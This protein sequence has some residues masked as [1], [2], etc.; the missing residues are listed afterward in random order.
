MRRW[1][2][3]V[4]L[5]VTLLGSAPASATAAPTTAPAEPS[6]DPAL[7]AVRSILGEQPALL[8]RTDDQGRREVSLAL[9]D[10]FVAMPRLDARQKAE[11][12]GYLARPTD[13][14][15][16]RFGDGYTVGARKKCR[17]HIC[18]HW[19]P[20]TA[21]APPGNAW[22]ETNLSYL[23]KVWRI[24]VRKL[25]YRKPIS[26]KR[27]GG[28]DKLDVYLKDLGGRGVY[29]YCAPEKRL[30]NRQ[31]LA[32]GYCV[33][34]NDFSQEQYGTPPRDTMRVTAAHEFFHAVQYSYDYGE[35]PWLM[36][37]TATW[38]EERVADD[39]NDNRQYLA[40][41]Q[42]GQ[43]GQSLD[44]FK[45]TGFNQYGNWAFFEYLTG[46]FG[47]GVVRSIWERAGAHRGGGHQYSTTA[48]KGVLEKR[49]GF[50]QV[51]R[52]FAVAN[53]VPGRTYD[54]G[55]AWPSAPMRKSWVLTKDARRVTSTPRIN[56][57]AAA[58]VLVRP[59][60]GVAA[61]G[62]KLRVVV[63]GPKK[64]TAPSA[65][66]LVK[67]KHGVAMKPIRLNGKGNGR[68]S[69]PFGSRKVR[70]ATVT[71]VNASTRFSCW[72]RTSWSCQGRARDNKQPFELT[73]TAVPPKR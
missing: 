59:G 64:R 46:R 5:A 13:G 51:F 21:D 53:A 27:R 54:E 9:R 43:P 60:A 6:L 39:V 18:V 4:V 52:G 10:L 41:G 12:Q 33:L 72:H 17:N 23:N 1:I 65:Y 71:L 15:A 11:A 29:G 49:G 19:V 61:R 48:V 73:V 45:Q 69:V 8:R 70:S 3:A 36:E 44:T 7:A 32:F 47:V 25:G 31:W 28:N 35:D 57:M 30:E 24:E 55:K 38:M 66:L 14:A 50:E 42:V 68:I 22:V 16:D 26:D 62:W 20:T 56:H 67:R 34:D 2:L 58:H 63:D 40:H 37:S